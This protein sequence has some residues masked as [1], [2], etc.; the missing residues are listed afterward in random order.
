MRLL[1]CH[2]DISAHELE[3]DEFAARPE[4]D[5]QT[6]A[7]KSERINKQLQ[8]ITTHTHT[9][10]ASYPRWDYVQNTATLSGLGV[11]AGTAH[12]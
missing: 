11:K 2:V 9:H 3:V 1:W 7:E 4:E 6:A 12:C 5:R 10:S 8:V